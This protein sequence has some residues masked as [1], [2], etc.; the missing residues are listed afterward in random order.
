MCEVLGGS[1]VYRFGNSGFG[2]WGEERKACGR[3]DGLRRIRHVGF[4][5]GC[6]AM[7]HNGAMMDRLGSLRRYVGA[8][9]SAGMRVTCNRSI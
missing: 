5:R 3:V 2:I 1:S 4:H 6:T 9:Q 7:I 8:A